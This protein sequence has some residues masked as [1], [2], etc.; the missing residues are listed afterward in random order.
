MQLSVHNQKTLMI[1]IHNSIQ[2]LSAR[3]CDHIFRGETEELINYPPNGGLTKEE[4]ASLEILKNNEPIKS[5][6][7]K[8]VKANN[9]D[10]L[11]ALFN[12]IDGTADPDP[13][14]GKWTEVLLIDRPENFNDHYEFLHDAFYETYWDWKEKQEQN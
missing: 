2:E 10:L 1:H 12:I 5:A 11:F 9:A 7:E 6:L 4:I 13:G 8:I 3:T 14:L